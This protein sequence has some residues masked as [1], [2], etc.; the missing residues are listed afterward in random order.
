MAS[1]KPTEI[2]DEPKIKYLKRLTNLIV[3]DCEQVLGAL[4]P[5]R[6]RE[7]YP[8][9]I[10]ALKAVQILVNKAM[11]ESMPD[12]LA[13][14]LTS[15]IGEVITNLVARQILG[16]RKYMYEIAEMSTDDFQ[17]AR[18]QTEVFFEMEDVEVAV[19]QI[20]ES[21]SKFG[22]ELGTTFTPAEKRQIFRIIA[23]RERGA[24]QPPSGKS[25]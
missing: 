19:Q 6:Q 23:K 4:T 22:L 11:A 18:Q 1:R 9:I 14:S 12:S 5:K 3:S 8:E 7:L 20:K 17:I 25:E 15:Q 24:K 21:L 10:N 13:N 16:Q 2:S